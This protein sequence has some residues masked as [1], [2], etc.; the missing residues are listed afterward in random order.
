[1]PPSSRITFKELVEIVFEHPI[2]PA[3]SNEPEVLEVD[4]LVPVR[5][6]SLKVG[7]PVLLKSCPK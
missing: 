2:P 5:V 6:M 3:T 7:V 1:M 4:V